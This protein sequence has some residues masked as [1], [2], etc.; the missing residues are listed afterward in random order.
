[1]VSTAGSFFLCAI[2]CLF[3]LSFEPSL[4]ADGR[5]A[6]VQGTSHA[7]LR[8][9]PNRDWPSIAI[10]QEGDEVIVEGEAG[11]WYRVV[12]HGQKGYVHKSLVKFKEDRQAQVGLAAKI[13][14]DSQAPGKPNEPS[15]PSRLSTSEAVAGAEE[16]KIK[17][18]NPTTTAE[19]PRFFSQFLEGRGDE[20]WFCFATG[21]VFFVIGWIFGGSY[22]LRRE[23]ARRTKLRF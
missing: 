22:Y 3:L 7:N 16:S 19:N 15:E 5:K 18:I 4:A 1:M 9:G 14:R 10:L 13:T 11:A 23:R 12:T 2:S 21:L 8:S 17:P 20:L 6:I